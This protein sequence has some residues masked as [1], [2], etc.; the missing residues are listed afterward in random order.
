RSVI[1]FVLLFVLLFGSSCSVKKVQ[2]GNYQNI[3]CKKVV[4]KEDKDML[5]FWNLVHVKKTEKGIKVKDYEKVS[6]RRF[7]DNVVFYGT[8]GILSFYTVKIYVKE[9]DQIEIKREEKR[10]E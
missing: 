8:A 2:V 3:D 1:V 10:T 4:Y 6:R 9:C 5:L 7:F